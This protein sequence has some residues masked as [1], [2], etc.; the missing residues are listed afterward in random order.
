MK[1]QLYA[2]MESS[3]LRMAPKLERGYMGKP[4]G[5]KP[6]NGFKRRTIQICSDSQVALLAIKSSKVNSQ[7][8]LECKKTIND[9]ACRNRVMLTWV[10]IQVSEGNEEADRLAREGSAL[11][12]IRHWAHT[13]G[14]L[15]NKGLGC[16]RAL[17]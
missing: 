4:H 16:Q 14:T 9:L 7:L 5:Q 12:P 13:R 15:L 8:V 11:Y 6:E 17:R 3:G 10:P 2:K 1:D